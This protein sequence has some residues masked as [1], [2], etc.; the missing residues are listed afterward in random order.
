MPGV[1]F[2][3]IE[4][5]IENG[6]QV[7]RVLAQCK[8]SPASLNFTDEYHYHKIQYADN[9]DSTLGILENHVYVPRN[10]IRI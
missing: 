3:V 5:L 2:L 4:M 10:I 8:V 1:H 6:G 9:P 7:A